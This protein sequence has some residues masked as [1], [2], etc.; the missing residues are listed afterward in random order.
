MPEK[1]KSRPPPSLGTGTTITPK[2][3]SS[4][5]CFLKI[6]LSFGNIL[7]SLWRGEK[8]APGAV[9]AAHLLWGQRGLDQDLGIGEW[10][11][12]V[13]VGPHRA[14][15]PARSP[16]AVESDRATEP[17]HHFR[18]TPRHN[19]DVAGSRALFR[20]R[21]SQSELC[22]W[23]FI[24]E[25]QRFSDH[26]KHSWYSTTISALAAVRPGAGKAHTPRP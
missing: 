9:S 14:W 6:W 12:S 10:R 4:G 22:S 17:G 8:P 3:S 16:I 24:L 18:H 20:V 2:Q 13:G 11:E 25:S 5:S 7:Y 1:H 21:R 15:R 23:L 26:G 19:G